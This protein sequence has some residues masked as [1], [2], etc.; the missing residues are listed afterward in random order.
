MYSDKLAALTDTVAG[1]LNFLLF[2]LELDC[3][4]V[5]VN[6][7]FRIAIFGTNETCI[8][9]LVGGFIGLPLKSYLYR[10]R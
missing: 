10:E 4:L 9:A 8:L 7:A 6:I 3:L 1:H 5:L 2:F